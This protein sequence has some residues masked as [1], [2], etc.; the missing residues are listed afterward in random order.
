MKIIFLHVFL[1]KSASESVY[2]LLAIGIIAMVAFV[3]MLSR[4][5]KTRH[6]KQ[7]NLRRREYYAARRNFYFNERL[8]ILRHYRR[9]IQEGM[10]VD[11]ALRDVRKLLEDNGN[12]EWHWQEEYQ[13]FAK[14]AEAYRNESAGV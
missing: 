13:R 11:D 12:G 6:Q 2:F 8:K 14:E 5:R 3:G 1:L 7:E 9:R 10:P 4:I